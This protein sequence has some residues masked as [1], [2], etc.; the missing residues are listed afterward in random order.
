MRYSIWR[1]RRGGR[2][3]YVNLSGF[4]RS[5][6]ENGAVCDVLYLLDCCYAL[7]LAIPWRKEPVAASADVGVVLEAGAGDSFTRVLTERFERAGGRAF[8]VAQ[9]HAEITRVF[10][11]KELRCAPVHLEVPDEVANREKIVLAP[12]GEERTA[13][14]KN[15]GGVDPFGDE[16]VGV[17]V[18]L[19]VKLSDVDNAS[20]AEE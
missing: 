13:V 5:M 14:A 19:S 15:Q 11:G 17:R 20:S 8:T 1:G 4:M 9:L 16:S 3:V 2:P 18:L 12:L 7:E 10:Y 6:V